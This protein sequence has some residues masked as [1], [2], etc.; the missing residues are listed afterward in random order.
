M[1]SVRI[2]VRMLKKKKVLLIISREFV[3][4]KAQIP[5]VKSKDTNFLYHSLLS[6][7]VTLVYMLFISGLALRYFVRAK[8]FHR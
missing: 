8:G 5:L 4:R 2:P 6:A 7:V 3:I 1:L